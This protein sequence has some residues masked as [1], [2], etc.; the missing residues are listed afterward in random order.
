M[1]TVWSAVSQVHEMLGERLL[2]FEDTPTDARLADQLSLL[3]ALHDWRPVTESEAAD[4][5]YLLRLYVEPAPGA[6]RDEVARALGVTIRTMAI[7]RA[8]PGVPTQRE[9]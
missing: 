2:Q 3:A 5:A 6:P 8:G 7:H 4:L 9:P 1:A